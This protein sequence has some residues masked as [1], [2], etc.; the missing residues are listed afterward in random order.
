MPSFI[1]QSG[2]PR[3]ARP[4]IYARIDASALAGGALDSGA[5]AIVGDFPSF[6]SSEPVAF[7]SRRAMA[8]FDAT[9]RDLAQLAALAFSPSDDENAN[10]GAAQ[11]AMINA[12]EGAVAA[13]LAHGPITLTSSVYGPRGNRLQGTL[14]INGDTHALSLNR[15]GLTEAYSVESTPLFSI[16]NNTGASIEYE[17]ETGTFTLL[18]AGA[19]TLLSVTSAEAPTARALV[20]LIDQLENISATLIDPINAPLSELDYL[21]GTIADGATGELKAPAFR[22]MRELSVSGL[23]SAELDNSSTA[24]SFSASTE[25]ATGGA[26]GSVLD[27]EAAL[28]SI[29]ALSYQLVVL[30]SLSAADQSKLG[31]H[32]DAAARAGYERQAYTAIDSTSALSAVKTRA[33]SL[34]APD[35]ALT[36][37]S[38]T[39]YSPTGERVTLDS[40][41]TALMFAAMQAGSDTAE[42]LT[43][44]RP[45]VIS[46]SQAWNTHAD[47]EEALRS[48]VIF[49]S[50]DTIGARIERGITTWL[51]DNN[52]IY[53]EISAYESLLV[54]VRDI[55][56]ALNDQIG[57][58]ARSSQLTLIESRVNAR[59]NAQVLD[60]TIKAFANVTLEDLGDQ[61]AVSYDAAPVEP[62]NF[63]TLTAVAR[64]I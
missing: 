49:M 39:I 22:L 33:A 46:F 38:I 13:T 21:S 7:S 1:T 51:E 14:T 53:S 16:T 15:N 17:L 47:A 56:Q 4:A 45:R 19:L 23:V 61:V 60:G 11:V 50:S 36:A 10:R 54:S 41:Y 2:F 52:P 18:D 63:I 55:R 5:L 40:R 37:Q 64:R 20:G 3:T 8:A 57:R 30:F 27:Y 32:L 44:K 9:D 26:Q 31:A 12:R 35:I 24:A 34:N 42:P 25:T 28:Q 48:G 29:E 6:P 59:L 43:R 58:P 62:L